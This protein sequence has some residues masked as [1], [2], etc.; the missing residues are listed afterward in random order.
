MNVTSPSVLVNSFF[1]PQN[2][3]N[4]NASVDITMDVFYIGTI[5][6][7]I[8]AFLVALIRIHYLCHK[9]Q[10]RSNKANIVFENHTKVHE[11]VKTNIELSA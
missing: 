11:L 1:P 5:I 7:L 9:K 2:D 10:V 8:V 4:N 6:G 3:K